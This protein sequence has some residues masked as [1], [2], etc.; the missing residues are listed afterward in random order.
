[1]LKK[2]DQYKE[3]C[4]D[5]RH[6]D[7]K[8]WLLPTTAFTILIL[9]DKAVEGIDLNCVAALVA[10]AVTAAYLAIFVAF[11]K[12]RAYQLENQRAI[13]KLTESITEFTEVKQ[14]ALLPRSRDPSDRWFIR[15]VTAFSATNFVVYIMLILLAL[16]ALFTV[17]II[18]SAW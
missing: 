17:T 5:G 16:Q 11:V 10:F 3:L 2:I 18:V 6:L 7:N 13:L 4:A 12:Y 8:M 9:G 14:Y 15:L 1:M